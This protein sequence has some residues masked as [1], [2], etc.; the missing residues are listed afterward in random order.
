[1][2]NYHHE[3]EQCSSEPNNFLFWGEVYYKL[4][5]VDINNIWKLLNEIVENIQIQAL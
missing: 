5:C 1:M 4:Q 3:N 2:C